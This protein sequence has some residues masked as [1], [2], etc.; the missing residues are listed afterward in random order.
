MK[1]DDIF[2]VSAVDEFG[3]KFNYNYVVPL[4]IWIME[5]R[6]I[7]IWLFEYMVGEILRPDGHCSLCRMGM[8]DKGVGLWDQHRSL[9]LGI[10]G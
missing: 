9:V 8:R 6:Q 7:Y 4:N 10:I 1:K 5:K 2:C 3:R